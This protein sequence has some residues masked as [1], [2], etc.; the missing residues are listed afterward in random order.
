MPNAGVNAQMA[1]NQVRWRLFGPDAGR[2]SGCGNGMLPNSKSAGQLSGLR[3][4]M[5]GRDHEFAE[6]LRRT[7]QPI[8]H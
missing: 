8:H 3:L 1:A 4:M 2:A 7:S 5:P 6:G